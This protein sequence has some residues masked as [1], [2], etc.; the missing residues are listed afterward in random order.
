MDSPG[1]Y[2]L[3]GRTLP[4]W[5]RRPSH[6]SFVNG[7]PWLLRFFD[8]VQFYPVTETELTRMRSAFA[9]GT[10]TVK[11]EPTV[12]RL[13]EHEAFLAANHTEITEFQVRQA[14]AYQQE[15]SLWQE[16][17][18][19]LI[20][21]ESVVSEVDIKGEPIAATISGN[22]WKLLVEP[23]EAVQAGQVV[24]IVE[25][26]KMEFAIEAPRD[27]VIAH[28]TCTP[29]QLVQMGQPLMALELPS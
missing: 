17:D 26:M 23:G 29:G 19:S 20:S 8:Q 10:L 11:A 14:V 18:G 4:I 27:G 9:A 24:V 25:A 7:K 28:C 1:G 12:F 22:V 6:P 3:V 16:D 5:N 13:A 15:I 21:R 2:Q